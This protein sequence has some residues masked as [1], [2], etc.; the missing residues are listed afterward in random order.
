MTW[1]ADQGF[2]PDPNAPQLAQMTSDTAMQ[3]GTV[4]G[5]AAS[6]PVQG[7]LNMAGGTGTPLQGGIVGQGQVLGSAAPMTNGGSN[8]PTAPGGSASPSAWNPDGSFNQQGALAQ[9]TAYG[10]A[11]GRSPADL[12]STASTD[13][14]YWLPKI[15][16][17]GPGQEAYWDSRMQGGGGGS[18]GSGG[19][20][21][22][23][24]GVNVQM[25]NAP[26]YNAFQGPAPY[27]PSS[28]WN[29]QFQ[30]PSQTPTPQSLS[31]N[32]ATA[33]SGY[34]Y[35]NF[36]SPTA[37]QAPTAAQA[38]AQPGY[39]FALQQGLGAI[40]NSAAAQGTLGSGNTLKGID[41]YASQAATQNYSNVLAQQQGIYQ[42][43]LGNSFQANQANNAGQLGAYSTNAQTGLQYNQ[44][45]NQGTNAALQQNNANALA[46]QGQQF[47]Q[48]ATGYGIQQGA[49]QQNYTQGI[50]TYQ[51]N[52]ANAFNVNQANNAGALAN[53][54][55]QGQQALG[56]GNLA[57]GQ[58]Y[59]GLAGN[60]QNY[61]QGLGLNQNAFNQNYE[62]AS[63]GNPG[64]PNYQG[65]GTG[66]GNTITN[67]G[68]SVA[69]GQIQQGNIYGNAMNNLGNLAQY[70]A[71]NYGGGSNAGPANGSF[72]PSTPGNPNL[73][74]QTTPQG[75]LQY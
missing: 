60:Q 47:G 42:Q 4:G 30:A 64:A 49:Q 10:A 63:L 41:D 70:G 39:Q 62:T 35:N 19:G 13:A 45:N 67:T 2:Q 29:Q 61:A 25:P 11:Q 24:G 40:Q 71:M 56:A 52:F 14:A 44:A 23:G 6:T 17:G 75:A 65:Y 58:G 5:A 3:A 28:T 59:Y 26:S 50:G 54:S 66:Q 9:M 22:G 7:G 53:Y 69:A 18:G 16:A 38:A 57:L 43:N 8:T 34:N 20:S 73:T 51:Q 27:T 12:A 31:Y 74:Y 32:P 37:F 46:A 15:Q 36:Q 55:A 21:G 1:F 72:T 68:N 33:P 48:A